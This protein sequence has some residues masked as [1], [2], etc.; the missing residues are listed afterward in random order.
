MG[1]VAEALREPDD[2]ELEALLV[3]LMKARERRDLA[4]L[5]IKEIEEALDDLL[6]ES[7]QIGYGNHDYKV[8][9]VRAVR[10]KVDIDALMAIS[11]TIAAQVIKTETVS[12]VDDAALGRHIRAGAFTPEQLGEFIT[13]TP[14]KTSF[15]ITEIRDEAYPDQEAG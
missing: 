3:Q 1:A 11:P 12:K 13:Q 15:R 6:T 7:I 4:N 9:P 2:Q 5:E 10:T 8:T 14:N